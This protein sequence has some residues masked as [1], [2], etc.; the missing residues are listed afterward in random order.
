MKSAM[1]TRRKVKSASYSHTP[2]IH[3]HKRYLYDKCLHV[4][5]SGKRGCPIAHGGNG[6]TNI[7]SQ[8]LMFARFQH[9][10]LNNISLH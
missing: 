9:F 4:A 7:Q 10:F 1:S 2:P 3:T 5:L 8:V 6:H